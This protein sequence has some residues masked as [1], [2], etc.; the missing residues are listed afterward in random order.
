[1]RMKRMMRMT[2]LMMRM[3]RMTM[4][5]MRMMRMMK[6]VEAVL[7]SDHLANPQST[8]LS[9]QPEPVPGKTMRAGLGQVQR[10]EPSVMISSAVVVLLLMVLVTIVVLIFFFAVVMRMELLL[11]LIVFCV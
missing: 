1:M 10:A 4:V 7:M 9:L 6:M 11:N 3:M 2:M 8:P 5:M